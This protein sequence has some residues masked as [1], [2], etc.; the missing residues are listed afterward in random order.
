MPALK[1]T[2]GKYIARTLEV[3]TA[4]TVLESALALHEESLAEECMARRSSKVA[5]MNSYVSA[6]ASHVGV[7]QPGSRAVNMF[8]QLN[9]GTCMW[10]GADRG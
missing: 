5:N 6:A 10:I 4:P 7:L 9:R 2:C 1:R 8:G 3:T